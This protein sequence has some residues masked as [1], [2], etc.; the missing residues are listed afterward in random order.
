MG[1]VLDR[2]AR[3]WMPKSTTD[4][5]LAH[6]KSLQELSEVGLEDTQ[7][8]DAGLK[9]LKDLKELQWLNLAGTQVSGSARG[10]EHPEGALKRLQ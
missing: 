8:T 10:L 2:G 1:W 4:I 3:I 9:Y 7:V 6:A 5:E